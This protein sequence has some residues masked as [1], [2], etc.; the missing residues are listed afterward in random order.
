[1]TAFHEGDGVP[2]TVIQ[3][4]LTVVSAGPRSRRLREVQLGFGSAKKINRPM[5]GHSGVAVA[6]FRS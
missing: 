4:G 1:M 6:S 3:A 5:A 2:V